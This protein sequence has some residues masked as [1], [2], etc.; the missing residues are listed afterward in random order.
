MTRIQ[1]NTSP[2]SKSEEL[3]S[4]VK[5]MLG[6]TPNMF[7][8]LAHSSSA[9]GFAV[10]GFT[11]FA[12]SRLSGALREQLALTVAGINGC[13][14][15]AS[16]HTALGKRNKIEESE[17]SNNLYAK[18][19]DAKTQAALTFAKKVVEAR[20]HITDQDFKAVVAAGY[21]E[22]EVLDIVTI[23]AFN[24][25]TNYIN[26]VAKVEIDFPV[27]SIEETARAA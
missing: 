12:A 24:T 8:T 5:K 20:G 10:A 23:V 4:G 2:D 16:A 17:L 22:S 18:S 25:F 3:L 13:G 9:L 6:S 21:S 27:V 19:A 1:P 26:E 15:C 14:Y 11:G 7:T